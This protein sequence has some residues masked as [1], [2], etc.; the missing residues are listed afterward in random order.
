MFACKKTENKTPRVR[1]LI[2]C[3][4]QACGNYSDQNKEGKI[5]RHVA[6]MGEKINTYWVSA[7]KC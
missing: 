2:K 1:N 6:C 3:A 7:G 5:N 4:E